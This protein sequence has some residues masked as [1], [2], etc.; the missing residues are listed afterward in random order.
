MGI[1]C[2]MK[3]RVPMDKN[4]PAAFLFNKCREIK[5]IKAMGPV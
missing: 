4:S 3:K 1:F 2:K 5:S